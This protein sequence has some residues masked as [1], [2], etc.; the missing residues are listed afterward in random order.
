M[1][2]VY[3]YSKSED[4]ISMSVNPG[5]SSENLDQPV[6]YHNLKNLILGKQNHEEF[7]R[8]LEMK[9]ANPYTGFVNVDFLWWKSKGSGWKI[10]TAA[11][12]AGEPSETVHGNSSWNPGCRIEVGFS[13]PLKW[14]ASVLWTYYHNETFKRY[15]QDIADTFGSTDLSPFNADNFG[16]QKLKYNTIDLRMSSMCSW[17]KYLVVNP[18]I[19][20]RAAKIKSD[21]TSST[22]LAV[23][24]ITY[25]NL[26]LLHF[27][28]FKGGGPEI[29]FNIKYQIP[30]SGLEFFGDLC[31]FLLYGKE[32]QF[33]T[34]DLFILVPFPFEFIDHH[35]KIYD[36]KFALESQIGMRWKYLFDHERRSLSLQLSWNQNLW[37]QFNTMS[38]SSGVAGSENVMY[39]G[40]NC[41]L[42]LE[43]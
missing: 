21:V 5:S 32:K 6:R 3:G 10:Y 23:Q 24:D 28:S 34:S 15:N 25:I 39:Y 13:T 42:G 11:R 7:D 26:A 14:N 4:S 40:L 17:T 12:R 37:Y 27:E 43:Y 36:L 9:S 38:F 29:G 41:G 2:W 33:F 35:D 1:N 8:K 22:G 31:T 20:M 18:Y 19:G 16:R 30:K